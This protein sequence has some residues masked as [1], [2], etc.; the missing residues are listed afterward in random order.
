MTS[1][2]IVIESCIKC[3]YS[4]HKGG[5]GRVSYVPCCREVHGKELSYN[6]GAAQMGRGNVLVTASPTG[7]IPDWCPLEDNS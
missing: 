3:P 2:K 1:K 5:F 4:D 6:V 7:V